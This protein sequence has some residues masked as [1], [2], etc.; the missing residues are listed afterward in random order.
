MDSHKAFPGPRSVP[1]DGASDSEP[2]GLIPQP[3]EDLRHPNPRV[4]KSAIQEM[5]A[6]TDK[7]ALDQLIDVAQHDPDLDVRCT[8][9]LGLGQLLYSEGNSAY[10]PE[11]DQ[12]VSP[13][14][15]SLARE[16]LKRI[17]DLL[18]SVC[19]DPAS[20]LDEK[21]C[22]VEAQS[23]FS[24]DTVESLIAQLYERPEKAA[25][26]SALIAMGRNGS[27]RWA[28]ILRQEMYG[29]DRDLQLEAITAT[30]EMS[31]DSLGKDLWRLTYSEDRTVMLAALWALGQTGWDDAFERLDELTLH[32]DPEIA[33]AADE[34]M[35][36]WLFYNGL[37]SESS[38][39]DEDALFPDAE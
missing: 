21:R 14:Y 36:E 1:A 35:E 39:E 38:E 33:D 22:A 16:D 26:L 7:A 19:R 11:T 28:E 24:N 32:E 27:Q 2:T 5:S 9:I 3:L 34:A 23:Y 8:A 37:N 18:L 10:D 6:G 25:K 17:Y 29:P 4:R 31:L 15:G 13:S 30:G 20:S 12:E